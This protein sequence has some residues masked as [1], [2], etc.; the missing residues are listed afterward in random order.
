[1]KTILVIAFS[2]ISFT[3][4]AQ[5]SCTDFKTGKFQI[6]EKGR[7]TTL[8]ERN[9]SFQIE[10][11]GKIEVKLKITWIDDCTYKLS[12]VNGNE[13]FW[14]TR[15]KDTPGEEVIVSIIKTNEKG[16]L[17]E[18]RVEGYEYVYRSEILRVVDL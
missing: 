18:S 8:I 7:P 10:H 12:F 11:V 14:E 16:Y 1:M 15:P 5:T 17:Q 6:I 3:T 9:E 13:A 4:I 2:L